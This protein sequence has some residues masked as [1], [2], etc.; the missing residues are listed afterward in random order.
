MVPAADN[1][2]QRPGLHTLRGDRPRRGAVQHFQIFPVGAQTPES[3]S[4]VD[5]DTPSCRKITSHACT[6]TFSKGKVS[7]VGLLG[8][9]CL[10]RSL[11]RRCGHCPRVDGATSVGCTDA[12]RHT[13]LVPHRPC[14][15]AN[16]MEEELYRVTGR[17]RAGFWSRQ[18]G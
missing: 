11:D 12:S 4:Q 6:H 1:T 18:E 3:K 13:L 17:Q 14:V 5:C 9:I 15:A 10:C 2:I 8:A 7:S 16:F